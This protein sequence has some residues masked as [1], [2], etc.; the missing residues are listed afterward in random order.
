MPIEFKGRLI[1]NSDSIH[2]LNEQPTSAILKPTHSW[3]ML[4]TV[5]DLPE[6]QDD[7]SWRDKVDLLL[8]H[9]IDVAIN[10]TVEDLEQIRH[11]YQIV[12]DGVYESYD[13]FASFIKDNDIP[14]LDGT[15][16]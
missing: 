8:Q 10:A 4:V 3:G 5:E 7:D 1:P 13:D 15:T 2:K 14:V 16:R 9:G 12:I 6:N 11:N